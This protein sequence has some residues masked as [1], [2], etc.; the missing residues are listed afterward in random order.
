MLPDP[1]LPVDDPQ[2]V[3]P[4][5]GTPMVAVQIAQDIYAL[6]CFH[7]L[8]HGGKNDAPCTC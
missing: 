8:Y 3:C 2:P 4:V 6:P 7:W 5:C 1:L